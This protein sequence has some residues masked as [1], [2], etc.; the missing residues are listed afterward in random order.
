MTWKRLSRLVLTGGCC[1]ALL[2]AG[3]GGGG[4]GGDG[5][6]SD[7]SGGSSGGALS[8][9]VIEAEDNVTSTVVGSTTRCLLRVRVRSMTDHLVSVA[10][11]YNAFDSARTGIATTSITGLLPPRATQTFEQFWVT[12]GSG[13]GFMSCA[14]IASF[15]LDAA[16]STARS[17]QQ[18]VARHTQEVPVAIA[19]LPERGAPT[20]EP[21]RDI[22]LSV[23]LLGSDAF[24]VAAVD[25][26]TLRFGPDGASPA[27]NYAAPIALHDLNGDGVLDVVSF[28]HVLETGIQADEEEAWLAGETREGVPFAG[29]AVVPRLE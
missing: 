22:L 4:G 20:G 9:I 7:G 21:R 6:G 19:L 24:D 23:A 11:V 2:L 3:C 5:G 26:T 14:R 13:G 8:G 18:G 16:V 29:C 17:A 25:Q 1:V 10:L 27:S 12:P 15:A 28:Y